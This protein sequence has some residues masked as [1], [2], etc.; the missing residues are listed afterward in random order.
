MNNIIFVA[1]FAI[2]AGT[3]VGLIFMTSAIAQ[4]NNETMMTGN[5]T[6]AG[7]E[8]MYYRHLPGLAQMMNNTSG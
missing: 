8:T 5:E 4:E 3:A 1:M 7:N 2:L 6:M